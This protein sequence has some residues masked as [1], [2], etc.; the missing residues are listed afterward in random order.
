MMSKSFQLSGLQTHI[1]AFAKGVFHLVHT[2]LGGGGGVKSPIHFHC[3]LHE[4]K[5]K[6][7]G[8]VQIASKI[9]YVLNERPQR[10]MIKFVW[11]KSMAWKAPKVDP[12]CT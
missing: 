3:V 1:V 2:H 10:L 6:G 9:T 12:R 11:P 8:G 7:G 4:E 5:R